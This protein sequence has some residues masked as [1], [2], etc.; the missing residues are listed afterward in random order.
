MSAL[1]VNEKMTLN[2]LTRTLTL[3][4]L[5]IVLLANIFLFIPFAIYMGNTGEFASSIWS[6]LRLFLIP[7]LSTLVILIVTGW[8]CR[9]EF[10][11]RYQ[12][13][14][15]TVGLLVWLQG[16]ILVWDYGYK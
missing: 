5:A 12:A 4:G 10:K 7:A 13:F 15:A 1:C 2:H 9:G 6:I 14:L 3:P 16:N 8:L 11:Y